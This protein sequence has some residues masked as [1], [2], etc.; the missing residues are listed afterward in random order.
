MSSLFAF[1][2]ML[3]ISSDQAGLGTSIMT[4]TGVDGGVSAAKESE[5]SPIAQQHRIV[6]ISYRA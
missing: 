6:F 1:V 4:A 3:L 5:L 2:W